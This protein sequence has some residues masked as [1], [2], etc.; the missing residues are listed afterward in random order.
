MDFKIRSLQFRWDLEDYKRN[1]ILDFKHLKKMW[2]AVKDFKVFKN[3][4]RIFEKVF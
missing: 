3:I 2:N 1:P 4:S